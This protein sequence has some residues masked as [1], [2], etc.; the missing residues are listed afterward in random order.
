MF[1]NNINNVYLTVCVLWV[2]KKT[3]IEL[4]GWWRTAAIEEVLV[5]SQQKL[6]QV[7]QHDIARALSSQLETIINPV[8]FVGAAF[9]ATKFKPSHAKFTNLSFIP[10]AATERERERDFVKI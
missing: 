3:H 8:R 4:T 9:R 5:R 6:Q 2:T 7:L 10:A 1:A